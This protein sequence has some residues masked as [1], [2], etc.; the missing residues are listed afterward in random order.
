MQ[1][2]MNIKDKHLI[3]QHSGIIQI[4]ELIKVKIK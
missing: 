1:K 3:S 2:R 4:Y